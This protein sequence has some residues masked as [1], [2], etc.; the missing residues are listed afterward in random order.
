M[1]NSS[2]YADVIV[3]GAGPVGLFV[4]CELAL[5]DVSVIV[6]ERDADSDNVWKKG[7]LGVR[8][9]Y[10]PALEAFY[11]RGLLADLLYDEERVTHL[12]K[13][14][15]FR[16]AGHFGGRLLNANAVDFSRFKYHLPGPTFLP[17]KTT[18]ADIECELSKRA[19]ERGVR[20]V[21]GVEISR[22]E[23]EGDE[24]TVWADNQSFKS[25][26]LVA[27][28]GGKSTIRKAAGFQFPGTDSELT[29][30]IAVCDVD[31]PELLGKGMKPT[32]AGMYIVS[33]PRHLYVM[34]FDTTFDRSQTVTKEHLER[35]LQRVSGTSVKIEAL[36][37]VS[38]FTDR[39]KQATQYRKGRIL[40]AGDSAH[41]HSPLGA[42][43]L[44]TGI[45]DAFN[46]GW[47]LA[48]TVKGYAS[49]DLLDTYHR[50]RQPEGA[51]TLDWSRSQVVIMR[52]DPAGKAISRLVTDYMATN[53]GTTFFV[54]KIWG[55]SRRYDL[56]G[57]QAHPLVGCSVPDFQFEGGSYL[58]SKLHEG[59]F[60]TVDFSGSKLLEEATDLVQPWVG[61]LSCSVK[62]RLGMNALLLRPD[63]VVAWVA[64]DEVKIDSWKAALSQWMILPGET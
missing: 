21:R 37:I 35:V 8:G 63:G 25:N 46:L 23:D 19:T 9:M 18:I 48:S 36:E 57:A 60:M 4:A 6:L 49:A 40:L 29:C 32:D 41:I 13:T 62:D 11:R 34:D 20:I 2:V 17:A 24:V 7:L 5:H 51:W 52:P 56:V 50:E 53:D 54:N 64:E 3:V 61:Y 22:V 55:I 15:G 44:T 59:K 1:T 38:T 31:K 47:K 43:G 28:D 27:C 10:K 58:G 39:C 14:S 30:Y 26:W 16:Y 45:A 12:E 33:G 42:Q